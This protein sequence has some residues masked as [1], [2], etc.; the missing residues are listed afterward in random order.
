[1]GANVNVI[2]VAEWSRV[3][4]RSLAWVMFK[5]ERSRWQRIL[6]SVDSQ[7][8]T[9]RWV[10]AAAAQRTSSPPA[11]QE[12]MRPPWSSTWDHALFGPPSS[13]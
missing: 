2:G 8:A 1:M 9:G 12:R 4:C 6:S 11:R 5:A 13:T 3:R 10:C 7:N